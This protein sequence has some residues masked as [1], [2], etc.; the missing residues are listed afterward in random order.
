MGSVKSL[1]AGVQTESQTERAVSQEASFAA[2]AGFGNNQIAWLLVARGSVGAD[3]RAK[4]FVGSGVAGMEW[5]GFWG[6]YDEA[7]TGW[8][9]GVYG[10]VAY[11][12]ND[13][14]D[15]GVTGRVFFEGGPSWVLGRRGRG[16]TVLSLSPMLGS[17][18][19]VWTDTEAWGL[20]LGLGLTVR[21]D[22]FD[23]WDGEHL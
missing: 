12:P 8:R 9:V 18:A 5:Q 14:R 3:M 11:F 23:W 22:H 20:L 7:T 10:G 21:W 1:L 17:S 2:S 6:H 16:F 4:H 15:H 19:P 13:A